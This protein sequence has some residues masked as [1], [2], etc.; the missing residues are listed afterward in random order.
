MAVVWAAAPG[1]RAAD[2]GGDAAADR[3]LTIDPSIAQGTLPNGVR[4]FVAPRPGAGRAVV[5]MRVEAGSLHEE[6]GEEGLAH[7]VEHMAFAGTQHYPRGSVTRRLAELGLT[8]GT[9]E[10]ATTTLRAT[11]YKL[12][13][14]RASGAALAEAVRIMADFAYRREP[15]VGDVARERAVILEEMRAADDY[16]ER[17]DAKVLAVTFAGTRVGTRLPLGA[18]R[19]VEG[20]GL[21]EI[22][23]FVARWYRPERT[24]LL[25][26]G[27]VD[28]AAVRE[29]VERELGPFRARTP[30]PREP[31][32]RAV[33][34]H[35]ARAAVLSDPGQ[36]F[37]EVRL[38]GN[39]AAV[40]ARTEGD[41]RRTLAARLATW[42]LNERLRAA[43]DG[44]AR[45]RS[46]SIQ[47]ARRAASVRR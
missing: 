39:P 5:W 6:P 31:D 11:T 4:Y 43:E 12:S 23:R 14:P 26:A 15:T 33:A 36:P 19:V 10:N 42:M 40:A 1:A 35:A 28:P 44:G 2:A 3:L 32:A 27:D 29:A 47:V 22:D 46:L 9:D 41:Y 17:V 8:F 34:A 13:L 30:P 38:L 37:A 24:S 7:F 25:V 20:A 16:G 21:H 18:A 45:R